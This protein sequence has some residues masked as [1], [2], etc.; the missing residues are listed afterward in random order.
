MPF[1]EC[2]LKMEAEYNIVKNFMP[3]QVIETIKKMD[4]SW[5]EKKG[6]LHYLYVEYFSVLL[7]WSREKIIFFALHFLVISLST[8]FFS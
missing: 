3:K 2:A 7:N 1:E 4:V 8:L 5:E 6:I